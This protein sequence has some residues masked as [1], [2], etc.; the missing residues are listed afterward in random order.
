VSTSPVW[1]REYESKTSYQL[2]PENKTSGL[3]GQ[4]ISL[5][6]EQ[7]HLSEQKLEPNL[8]TVSSFAFSSLEQYQKDGIFSYESLEIKEKFVQL[9]EKK[10]ERSTVTC[11]RANGGN[12][13]LS[14]YEIP[15]EPK[16]EVPVNKMKPAIPKKP[17]ILKDTIPKVHKTAFP[18][19]KIVQTEKI[20][21]RAPQI[22]SKA[23]SPPPVQETVKFD[24]SKVVVF[25]REWFT[26]ESL[27][28][29]LG[30]EKS[31]E[32]LRAKVDSM[33]SDTSEPST[34]EK[35]LVQLC[36]QVNE[37][38]PE[39]K[40]AECT[41]LDLKVEAFLKGRTS[42]EVGNKTNPV[43][44]VVDRYEQKHARQKIV[45]TRLDKV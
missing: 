18:E 33:T 27:F 15:R 4:E 1:F 29:I 37:L 9:E 30:P 10:L 3:A 19:P 13:D 32:M 45:L 41:E 5:Q 34:I 8:P 21:P 12:I 36:R 7:V 17:I 16:K 11:G 44:P 20:L 2:L 35:K 31:L 22:E 42:Y 39:G 28:H 24:P 43:L 40:K 25:A 14:Q 6:L 26:V 23:K 38:Q